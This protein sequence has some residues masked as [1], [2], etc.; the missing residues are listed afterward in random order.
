LIFQISL[1]FIPFLGFFRVLKYFLK[2]FLFDFQISN[3]GD[4]GRLG[5]RLLGERGVIVGAQQLP[6]E[7]LGLVVADARKGKRH[8][9]GLAGARPPVPLAAG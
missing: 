7:G 5:E 6:D 9:A 2:I 1:D 8:V 4:N 3:L